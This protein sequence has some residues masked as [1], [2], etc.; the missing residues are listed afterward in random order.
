MQNHEGQ[1]KLQQP[2]WNMQKSTTTQ[3]TERQDTRKR[4]NNGEQKLSDN[5]QRP[6]RMEEDCT[7]SQGPQRT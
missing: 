7:G 3:N 2:Q 5:C 1:N 6:S 4:K